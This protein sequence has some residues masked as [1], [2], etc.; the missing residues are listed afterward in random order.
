[1][2]NKLMLSMCLLAVFSILISCNS[3]NTGS[4]MRN[5]TETDEAGENTSAKGKYAI[6]SG[7]VEYSTQVMGMDA[8]QML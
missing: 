6:K 1:M 5:V 7:I 3:K 8:K 2:K 4:D